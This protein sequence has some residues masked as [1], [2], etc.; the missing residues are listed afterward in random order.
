[1]SV[2]DNGIRAVIFDMDGT[3]IDTEK[4]YRICWPAA[5]AHFGYTMT[6]EQHLQIRSLGRP[7]VIDQFKAW[8]GPDF[9]YYGIKAYRGEIFKKM[10]AEKGIPV[11]PG[12]FELLQWLRSREIVTAIAT[13]TD[14]ERTTAYL[15]LT[16]LEG[17]FDAICCAT[18]VPQGKPS[19]EIYRYAV[20]T[21]G[22][23]A[24]SCIAVEDSPNGILSAYRAGL[25][26]VYVPD[27]VD[28]EPTIRQY[29][30]RKA[31]SLS[32]LIDME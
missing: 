12:A 10:V 22:L 20:K 27:L 19:P 4:Y 24:E 6:P 9:D 5:L 3:L 18:E 15:R 32:K 17:N 30:F 2:Y 23:P 14:R 21:V 16:G 8:Y 26:P 25:K 1:M 7:F 13:A 31:A 29:L 28:D 11:K